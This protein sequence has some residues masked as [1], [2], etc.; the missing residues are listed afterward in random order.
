[1]LES[2]Q[3]GIMRMSDDLRAGGLNEDLV[4]AYARAC[5]EAIVHEMACHAR[6]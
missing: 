3:R 6:G 4:G 1:M 2:V 5:A